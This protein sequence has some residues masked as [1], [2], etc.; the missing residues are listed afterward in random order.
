MIMP[1][2]PHGRRP[3]SLEARIGVSVGIL[4]VVLWIG[5]ALVTAAVV[6]RELDQVFDST[7]Q[8]TAERLLPL[9]VVDI[10][11]REEDD[12][13]T[14]QLGVIRA[15]DEYFTYIVRDDTGRILLQSHAA[16]AGIFP[17]WDGSGF[18][19]TGTHRLF[20]EA[21]L[22][23][24]VRITVA[25]PLDHRAAISREILFGLG[26]PLLLVLPLAVGAIVLA[27]RRSLAPLRR[28]RARLEARSARD[29]SPVPQGDLPAE[30]GPLAATL[31]AL[32]ARLQA[33]F[34][35]E[36]SF[37]A[38]A[39]HELRTPLAGAIAQAQRLQRETP[40]AA[41]R[42]RA[43]EIEASLKRLA[44]VA[45]RLLELA[46][47]EGGPLR[48][49]GRTADLRD[50]ARIVLDDLGRRAAPGQIRVTLPDQPVLSDL[51]PDAFGILCRNLVENALRHG[52]DGA[53][54][55]VVLA[56][57][58]LFQVSNEGP[59]IPPESLARLAERFERGGAGT[60]GS[61]L[62]LA[63]V[64]AIAE[65]ISAPLRLDSPRPGQPTGFM[66]S[67]RLPVAEG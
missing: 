8:E 35:A 53:P 48:L 1:A 23:G 32:L 29:L 18:R 44:R 40:D 30:I 66:A 43:A 37:A 58:G 38:N 24:T 59:V 55:D 52:T 10:I 67:L 60:K 5:A 57:D 4:L 64:A 28:F 2:Q 27:V 31:N 56:G 65:R 6:R 9:A 19:Q 54:V 39:A 16:D 15:R 22:S 13:V 61:G 62:G 7:L 26:L 47:A 63:I 50:V 25:E 51:D 46:R 41:A 20:S 49:E 14:Q 12:V 36:R 11:G 42:Q 33:A 3:A 17:P 21:A 34:E 45:E